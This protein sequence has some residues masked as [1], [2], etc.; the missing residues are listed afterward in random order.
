MGERRFE[1]VGACELI[2]EMLEMSKE[3]TYRKG[4]LDN[5]DLWRIIQTIEN[6]TITVSKKAFQQTF[7]RRTENCMEGKL[8]NPSFF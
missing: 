2:S 8:A 3:L 7:K 6:L 5:L 4:E 1:S